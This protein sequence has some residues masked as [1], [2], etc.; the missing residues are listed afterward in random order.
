MKARHG[1]VSR[2]IYELCKSRT[3]G[4]VSA[5]VSDALGIPAKKASDCLNHLCTQSQK[6]RRVQIPNATPA[7]YRYFAYEKV[8]DRRKRESWGM[9]D[10]TPI[11]QMPLVNLSEGF[12]NSD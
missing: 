10:G 3:Q 7:R 1:E 8:V 2:K 11:E 4:T 12:A 5:D 6:L 9:Y